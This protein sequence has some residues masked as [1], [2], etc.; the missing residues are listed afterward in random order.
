MVSL[1]FLQERPR[2]VVENRIR[3]LQ[4]VV[5]IKKPKT[6]LEF[7]LP[8]IIAYFQRNMTFPCPVRSCSQF[9]QGS[10]ILSFSLKNMTRSAPPNCLLSYPL[11]PFS[12][13]EQRLQKWFMYFKQVSF[14]C[15]RSK[16]NMPSRSFV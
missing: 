3:R 11:H 8:S 1:F 9:L 5:S 6:S 12:Y 13:T 14:S 7:G 2:R 10:F 15:S 4:D 16:R